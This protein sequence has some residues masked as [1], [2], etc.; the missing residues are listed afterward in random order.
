MNACESHFDRIIRSPSFSHR[1]SSSMLM[2]RSVFFFWRCFPLLLN[3]R[4]QCN[5]RSLKQSRGSD[6]GRDSLVIKCS[7]SRE[8]LLCCRKECECVRM[9]DT[10][11]HRTGRIVCEQCVY[12]V[13]NHTCYTRL[14]FARICAS[15]S[16][17]RPSDYERQ[18]Q[19]SVNCSSS[20]RYCCVRRSAEKYVLRVSV[21]GTYA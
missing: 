13:N 20:L 15:Q 4:C 2:M 14:C 10:S 16:G 18:V 12:V 17:Q 8:F 21:H 19:N 11:G 5:C 6:M 3:P 1:Y 7:Y 9:T